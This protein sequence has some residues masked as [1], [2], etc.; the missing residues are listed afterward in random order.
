MNDLSAG[1]RLGWPQCRQYLLAPGGGRLGEIEI[2][3]DPRRHARTAECLE[4]GIQLT[5]GRAE[6]GVGA[7]TQGQHGKPHLL[8]R[9][10]FVAMSAR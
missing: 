9:G 2:A 8:K 3:V 5:T 1:N 7:I 4:P 6:I 10:A